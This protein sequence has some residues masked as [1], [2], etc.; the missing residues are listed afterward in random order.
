MFDDHDATKARGPHVDHPAQSDLPHEDHE[1][2][3]GVKDFSQRIHLLLCKVCNVHVP[4]HGRGTAGR[5]IDKAL[6]GFAVPPTQ[7]KIPFLQYIHRFVICQ[8][9]LQRRDR[10]IARAQRTEI[11]AGFIHAGGE[12]AADPIIWFAARVKT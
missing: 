8:I 12:V 10:N 4:S 6:Y 2:I 11:G 5:V 9:Q 1:R 7:L 3:H